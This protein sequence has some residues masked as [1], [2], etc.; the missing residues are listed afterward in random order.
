M[1]LTADELANDLRGERRPDRSAAPLRDEDWLTPSAR[2]EL[3]HYRPGHPPG[4]FDEI[5]VLACTDA[6]QFGVQAK[7]HM[8]MGVDFPDR[9]AENHRHLTGSQILPGSSKPAPS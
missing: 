8:A 5:T 3:E 1:A 2:G 9:V 7:A 4:F 6:E